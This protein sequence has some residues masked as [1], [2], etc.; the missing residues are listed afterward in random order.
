MVGMGFFGWVDKNV[1]KLRWYDMSMVKISVAAFILMLAKLWPD[2]LSLEW[3]WYGVIFV[4]AA[5]SPMLKM[6]GK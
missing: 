6:F 1:G 4:L 2:L 3:Y 5:I